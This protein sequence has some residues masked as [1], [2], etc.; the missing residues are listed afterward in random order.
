MKGINGRLFD[1]ATKY[2]CLVRNLGWLENERSKQLL[3]K[4]LDK[5]E[6]DRFDATIELTNII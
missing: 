4:A 2:S 3:K 1:W 6:S 5:N